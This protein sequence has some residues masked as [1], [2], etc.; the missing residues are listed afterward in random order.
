MTTSPQGSPGQPHRPPMAI[1]VKL[2]HTGA[3]AIAH[4]IAALAIELEAAG[5]DSLW[6]SDHIV[7]PTTV[8]SFYPFEPDGVVRWPTDTPYVEAL[9]ALAVAAA[10]TTRPRLGTAAL[11]LPQR[12]P[13]V[14]AKQAAS[15]ELV[16]PGRLV[17]GVGAGWLREEF[18]ALAAP[19]DTRGA[20]MVEWI[21]LLR[22]CWT[23]HPAEHSTEHYRL[24]GGMLM[25]PPP[26]PIPLLV[27][28]HSLVALR[29]AGR[30]GDGWL[31]QQAVP[32][33]DPHQLAAEIELVRA[34]ATAAGRAPAE[35]R[36]VLRL[37]SSV[38]RL[39]VVADRLADL[40]AAGVHEIIVD[41]DIFSGDAEADQRLLRAAVDAL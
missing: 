18:D 3:A 21:A 26:G 6:V 25:Q 11:V 8:S 23:G 32:D 14:L 2:P 16:A 13:V 7:F 5:F 36:I 12:N 19:F 38:G 33:L 1:G 41:A 31:A 20:R 40:A 34:A 10:V 30:I 35:L 15:I 27:G 24:A 17:L 29:R 4:G 28:G 39:G 22:D 37:V 9:I